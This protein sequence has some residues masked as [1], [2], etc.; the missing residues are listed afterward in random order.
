M[1]APTLINEEAKTRLIRARVALLV[2]QPFF[3]TLA[4]RLKMVPDNNM[5]MKTMATDGKHIYY[6]EE[7]VMERTHDDLMFIVGHEVGHCVFE[8][9]GRREGRDP[10]RWN[11]AADYVV[12]AILKD[13]D[14]AIPADA[15]YS[16]IYAGWSTDEIYKA[17]PPDPPGQSAD[18]LMEDGDGDGGSAADNKAA[19]EELEG[20]WKLATVQAANAAAAAGNLPNTLKRFIDELIRGKDDWR[21]V[22]WRFATEVTKN[23][24]SYSRLNRKFASIGIYLPGLYSEAM[25]LF[26]SNI[27]TSGSISQEVLTAFAS[28]ITA[29]RDAVHPQQLINIYC[30]AAVNHIDEFDEYDEL[31]FDMHGGGGTDFRPPFQYIADNNLEPKC[32]V[33]LTDGYGPFPAVAPPYPVLWLMTTNVEPPWGEKVRIEV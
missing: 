20:D 28:E 31:H 18:E 1:N 6:D 16:P 15:L 10:K 12:N 11:H 9:V 22:L 27:D 13:A 33:Y 5:K 2:K 14:F 29:I 32:V 17:L 7:F 26:I 24:Y 23:D 21:G 19:R 4:L 3:G 30:D 8:H 25:G